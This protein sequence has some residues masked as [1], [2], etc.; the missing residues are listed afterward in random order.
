MNIRIMSILLLAL[1]S[2]P[3]LAA[4][5]G[6]SANPGKI[7]NTSP[8]QASSSGKGMTFLVKQSLSKNNQYHQSTITTVGCGKA[9]A[10]DCDAYKGDTRCSVSLPVLCF[11]PL[12]NQTDPSKGQLHQ[13]ANGRMKTIG[14]YKGGDFKTLSD[15]NAQCAADL[16]NSNWRVAQFH[17]NPKGWNWTAFGTAPQNRRFWVNIK[18]QPANCWSQ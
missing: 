10:S 13:W 8:M 3:A 5:P 6:Q 12:P 17:E 4:P 11:A 14:P 1:C 16:G 15:V 18:D 7:Y 2:V 9:G